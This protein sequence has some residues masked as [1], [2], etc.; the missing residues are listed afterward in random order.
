LMVWGLPAALSEILTVAL[1]AP[2]AVGA[3]TALIEQLPPAAR[4]LPQVV[5]S[6]KSPAFAPVRVMLAI[7][8]AASPV[9]LRVTLFAAL[10]VPTSCELKVRPEPERLT[11]GAVAG[12]WLPPPPPP[13]HAAQTLTSNSIEAGSRK[14]GRLVIANQLRNI[15][16]M[17][18]AAKIPKNPTGR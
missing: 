2:P 9:L 13:P 16:R 4:V 12:G 17:S 15:A 3:N 7:F 14:T 5:V 10:V 1:R 18:S 11:A 6:E 8:K